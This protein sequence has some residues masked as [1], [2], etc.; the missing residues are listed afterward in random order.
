M[1]SRKTRD[2]D[3]AAIKGRSLP[4]KLRD[5]VLFGACNGG[6]LEDAALSTWKLMDFLDNRTDN[7]EE[8]DRTDDQTEDRT[9]DRT[10]D[11]TVPDVIVA[12]SVGVVPVPCLW[13]SL[14]SLA[15]IRPGAAP[16]SS[17]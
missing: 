11:P 3:P 13:S 6:P 14:D 12:P 8:E 15:L 16:S 7:P 17:L 2:A 4:W 9:D 5:L 1:P 10:D